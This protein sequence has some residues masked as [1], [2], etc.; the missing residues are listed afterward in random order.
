MPGRTHPYQ[1]GGRDSYSFL[2]GVAWPLTRI[3]GFPQARGRRCLSLVR[4]PLQSPDWPTPNTCRVHV[5]LPSLPYL[6]GFTCTS[7]VT[8]AGMPQL[9]KRWA[10]W[11]QR[12]VQVEHHLGRERPDP[13]RS[14][15]HTRGHIP[16]GKATLEEGQHI[17]SKAQAVSSQG[18]AASL[19]NQ[20][21]QVEEGQDYE[22]SGFLSR[23]ASGVPKPWV[24]TCSWPPHHR[25]CTSPQDPAH[26]LP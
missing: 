3:S 25:H 23:F 12:P 8:P 10:R 4:T 2:P 24:S 18:T 13:K 21:P 17:L 15:A 5:P 6:R 1:N 16:S 22:N 26:L 7:L 20:G 19:P 9:H 11:I 14:R